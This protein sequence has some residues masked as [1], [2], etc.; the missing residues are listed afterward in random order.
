M[1]R[2]LLA[3][4]LPVAV[5]CQS[6]DGAAKF[7]AADIHAS[8]KSPNPF[9]RMMPVRAGR[10]ELKNATMVDLIHTAYGID[11]DK[12]LGGPNWL[13]MN[14]YDI[15]AKVPEGST[16]D[17]RKEMLQ[18]LLADRFQLAIRKDTKPLSTYA[19]VLA[20]K[21]HQLKEAPEAAGDAGCKPQTAS[22]PMPEGGSRLMISINGAPT[23]LNLG[24]G[25]LITYECRNMTMAGFA[26]N[27]HMMLGANVGNNPILDQTGLEGRWNFD[28]QWSMQLMGPIIATQTERVTF[29]EALEKQLGLKLEGRQVPTPVMVVDSVNA[30]P[31]ENPP[32]TA[33]LLPPVPIPSEFEVASVKPSDPESRS[34]RLNMQPGGRFESIGMPFRFLIVRAFNLNFNLRDGIVGLPAWVDTDRWDIQAKAPDPG[35]DM[36]PVDIDSVGPMV[37]NLLKER[38]QL[39]YHKEER[40]VNA[41]TL[42]AAKPKLKKAD[43]N[44]RSFCKTPP[45]TASTPPGSRVF[46]C[47]NVTMEQFAERLQNLS[48]ELTW[49][50]TNATGLEGGWDLTLTFTYNNVGMA[51]GPPRANGE[52]GGPALPSAAEPT[53]GLTIF[54]AM[55]KQLGLKLVQQKRPMPLVIID[56]LEQKPTEN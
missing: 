7:L 18:A 20:G 13:E 35:P 2:A 49:P 23:T 46:M 52:G 38:F 5:W 33:K 12:V 40:P 31:T 9:F 42:T 48:Q 14:R 19:L 51:A 53:A 54:E 6:G 15:V 1:K 36:P 16:A 3:A 24:P 10:F 30:K 44:S 47:Q 22:G 43:P 4:V 25:M 37:L 55:E 8:A 45:P 17:S 32:D 56:H 50:V 26:D 29:F 34:G 11:N 41:Y 27:L 39:A 28:V 21:K